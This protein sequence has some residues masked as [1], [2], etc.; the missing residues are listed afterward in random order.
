VRKYVYVRV[1]PFIIS[2][3]MRRTTRQFLTYS[4]SILT[5]HTRTTARY[6]I[7][8]QAGKRLPALC[9]TLAIV[10]CSLMPF[11]S[12]TAWGGVAG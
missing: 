5:M 2:P 1:L 12:P 10:A 9:L 4:L 3:V 11:A 8:R 6:S 7:L